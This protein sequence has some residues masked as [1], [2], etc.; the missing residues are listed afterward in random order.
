MA[1]KVI[2]LDAVE[3]ALSLFGSFDENASIIEKEFGVSLISRGSSIKLVG[4]E[5][6]V[7]L[8]ARTVNSLI[9]I[10][11]YKIQFDLR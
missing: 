5:E 7:A 8:A 11:T 9:V 6:Q 10:M 3:Q 4:D 2:E 1:E